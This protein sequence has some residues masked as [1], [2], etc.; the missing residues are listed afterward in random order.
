MSAT[1]LILQLSLKVRRMPMVRVKQKTLDKLNKMQALRVL[2]NGE[3]P[4]HNDLIDEMIDAQPTIQ[5]TA[6]D[7]SLKE[8]KSKS[9]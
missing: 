6:E 3:K 1:A 2:Q 8:G 9:S 7:V 4:S 5:V